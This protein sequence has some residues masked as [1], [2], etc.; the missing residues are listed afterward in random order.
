MTESEVEER[1]DF[2]VSEN[3]LPPLD[4][5]MAVAL[6]ARTPY[7]GLQAGEDA[8]SGV[9]VLSGVEPSLWERWVRDIAAINREDA[10][11]F[12]QGS[13]VFRDF[14]AGRID[15]V[16]H[17]EQLWAGAD[18]TRQELATA[19]IPFFQEVLRRKTRGDVHEPSIGTCLAVMRK[20]ARD[21]QVVD[22]NVYRVQVGGAAAAFV[23][24]NI[25]LVSGGH[26]GSI[27]DVV[28]QALTVTS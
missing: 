5:A 15:Y 26:G 12:S 1:D 16:L 25:L 14:L 11:L 27:V 21:R 28:E 10:E 17:P 9:A 13:A 7:P 6:G 8:T 2:G 20:V 18:T 23:K 3:Y 24:P 19:Y 22:W 4:F